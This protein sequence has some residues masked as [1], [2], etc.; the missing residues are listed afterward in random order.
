MKIDKLAL[1]SLC[2][3]PTT[4]F[5]LNSQRSVRCNSGVL[6]Q[7][8]EITPPPIFQEDGL[9]IEPQKGESLQDKTNPLV[10][11]QKYTIG[12]LP[13]WALVN[14]KTTLIDLARN[15]SPTNAALAS[16]I[17]RRLEEEASNGNPAFQL[18]VAHYSVVANAWAKSNDKNAGMQA[19]QV[20]KQL[21]ERSQIDSSLVPN[22]VM[23]NCIIHAWSR[24]GNFKQAEKVFERM[25]ADPYI[26]VETADYNA[27][28]AAYARNRNPRKA[29]ELLKYM[30]EAETGPDVISYNCILDS[31]KKSHE[32][33]SAERAESILETMQEN[34]DAGRSNVKPNGRSYSIVASAYIKSKSGDAVIH[35][36][37][38]L[39]LAEQRGVAND[40]YLYNGVLDALA[41]SGQPDVGQKAEKILFELEK[42]GMVNTIS[43]N[44][45]IKAW[46]FSHHKD[47]AQRAKA[48]L[49]RMERRRVSPDVF[50][51]T[52]VIHC[53]A[54]TDAYKALE[55]FHRMLDACKA[56]NNNVKPNTVT[57]NV[58]LD[59]LAKNGDI[60]SAE[61]AMKLLMMF[62]NSSEP[63]AE[64]VELTV[65]S[66]TSVIDA[67]G[68]SR[69]PVGAVKAEEVFE[70]MEAEFRS[71]NQ[72]AKPTTI[73][74]NTLMNAWVQTGKE[75]SIYHAEELLGRMEDE[76]AAG[77]HNVRPDV[78]SY[79]I[80]MN[81][82]S[83]LRV[84]SSLEKTADAFNRMV[85][86]YKAGNERAKPNL[87][88]FVS[89][90]QATVHSGREDAPDHAEKLLRTVYADYV[91]GN[92]TIK[93]N[94]KAF[95]LVIDSWAKSGKQNAGK[96]AEALLDW[97]FELYEKDHDDSFRPNQITWCVVIN[98]W[99][100]SRVFGKA[101]GAKAVLDRMIKLYES[102][103]SMKNK[104]STI[105]YTAVINAAAYAVEDSAEKAIA[106]QIAT[107]TF[108]ELH[109]SD[110]GKPNDVTYT[111]YITAC[112]N[113]IPEEDIRAS[114]IQV[115]FK[116]CCKEGMLSNRVLQRLQSALTEEQLKGL[117]KDTVNLNGSTRP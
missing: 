84:P 32:P 35:S 115:M 109:S 22:R 96:R 107:D 97:M 91:N 12:S 114:T 92:K 89:L 7:S 117:M 48:L 55:L 5:L 62:E 77:N 110:Y 19:E 34:F 24:Q 80:I 78:V 42:K 79:S 54:N 14:S 13:E 90:L 28:L 82:W 64:N 9:A 20:L 108:K 44:T 116:R 16:S 27:V 72:K 81:G 38:L 63:Y 43:Y 86:S 69:D 21:V 106:F 102:S 41:S 45:V 30:V 11:H 76:Y 104:P 39:S 100:K 17:L 85:K 93:P 61:E 105:A 58:V 113:L 18:D 29:E 83:K 99:A 37:R 8:T 40:S 26:K 10:N 95:T 53:Y 49:D 68:K 112:Q 4:S 23:Y 66:F 74:F 25:K 6:V 67:F 51:Y 56:G 71:G 50:T 52:S 94:T 101:S 3:F 15:S 70:Q 2:V 46:R 87:H 36:E 75:G 57:L 103:P 47:A 33:G 73:S 31:W 88:S 60:K 98:A 59:A 111:A 65:V 1:L